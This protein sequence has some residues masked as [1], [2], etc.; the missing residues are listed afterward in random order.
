MQDDLVSR[1]GWAAECVGPEHAKAI[2]EAADRITALEAS[3]A[4]ERRDALEEAARVAEGNDH[5]PQE[6]AHIAQAIR[7]LK[8]RNTDNA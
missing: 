6:G 5:F 8:A 3:L 7:A 2:D 4:A 1:L